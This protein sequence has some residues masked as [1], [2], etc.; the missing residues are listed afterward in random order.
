MGV[1]FWLRRSTIYINPSSLHRGGY[2]ATKKE[3]QS[4]ANFLADW[5]YISSGRFLICC[6]GSLF[7]Y[8]RFAPHI[9]VPPLL[10][11]VVY[12]WNLQFSVIGILS[13]FVDILVYPIKYQRFFVQLSSIISLLLLWVM[14]IVWRSWIIGMN[15]VWFLVWDY[16]VQEEEGWVVGPGPPLHL[17]VKIFFP[18]ALIRVCVRVVLLLS[19]FCTCLSVISRIK[20]EIMLS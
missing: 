14:D 2:S 10:F 5:W 12:I 15:T 13:R 6:I 18:R 8:L 3:N 17:V 4:W 1:C 9:V 19:R 7:A 11:A 20:R 16:L